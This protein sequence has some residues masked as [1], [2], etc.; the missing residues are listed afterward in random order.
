[1]A[2]TRAE[3]GADVVMS[4]QASISSSAAVAAAV[5]RYRASRRISSTPV[6]TSP[7]TSRLSSPTHAVDQFHARVLAGR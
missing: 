6:L 5:R 4:N 2:I 7:S 3:P 1:M